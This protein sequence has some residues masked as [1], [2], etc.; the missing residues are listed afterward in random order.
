MSLQRSPRIAPLSPPYEPDIATALVKWMPPGSALEPL[1]LFRT[2]YQNPQLSSR[3]HP[4]GAGIL[5]PKSSLDSHE[6]EIIIDRTCA[7]C[8]CEYEWG[9]HVAAFG[10]ACGLNSAQLEDTARGKVEE[11]LWSEREHV[12]IR[13]VDELHDTATISDAVWEQLAAMWNTAQ[14]LEMIIIVGWYHLISFVANAAHVEYEPW[15]ARFP[16]K[17]EHTI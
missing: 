3:M 1:K 15:A 8:E 7:R 6:R 11:A 5:G 2:L 13:L 4:L 12:L 17:E 16:Q 14:V 9:V 10:E